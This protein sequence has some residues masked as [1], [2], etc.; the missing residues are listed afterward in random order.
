MRS[1]TGRAR[2]ATRSD[3]GRYGRGVTEWYQSGS[4]SWTRFVR[5]S[6]SSVVPVVKIFGNRV[7]LSLN[8]CVV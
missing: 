6:M 1:F 8:V 2:V 7:V 5:L 4:P 3:P